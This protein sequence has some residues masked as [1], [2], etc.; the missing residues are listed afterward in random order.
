MLMSLSDFS[1][2]KEKRIK[3]FKEHPEEFPELLDDQQYFIVVLDA[4]GE[5]VRNQE[6]KVTVTNW[7]LEIM[8]LPRDA[9]QRYICWPVE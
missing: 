1:G 8:A 4:E 3:Y 6:G 7:S 9:Q 2:E 5:L